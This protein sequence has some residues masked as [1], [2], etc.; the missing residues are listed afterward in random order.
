MPLTRKP[1]IAIMGDPSEEWLIL[2]MAAQ[3]LGAIVY[4]IYPT[5]SAA[6][7]EFQM[8]DGGAKIFVAGDQE[9]LDKILGPA[10]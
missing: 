5:A 4:G 8:S 3:S 10:M 1:R 9:Y 2:D 6:E 7:V